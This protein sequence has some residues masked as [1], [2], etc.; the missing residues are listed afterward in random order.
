MPGLLTPNDVRVKCCSSF[1]PNPSRTL[2]Q[3]SYNTAIAACDKLGDAPAA[4]RLLQ[5]AKESSVDPDIFTYN[6]VISALGHSS[7]WQVGW[8]GFPV[9]KAHTVPQM[10]Y[11]L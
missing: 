3:V 9:P 10:W 11:S 7:L 5:Q 6:S 2:P 8:G 1:S 4:L